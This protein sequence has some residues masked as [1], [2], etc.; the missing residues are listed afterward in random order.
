MG[1][2]LQLLHVRRGELEG[3]GGGIRKGW[4]G[5]WVGAEGEERRRFEVPVEHLSHPLF[6]ELLEAAEEEYGFRQQGA[7]TIPC[8]VD[9]FRRVQTI[10]HR[11]CSYNHHH[12]HLCFRPS[13]SS[14]SMEP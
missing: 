1:V 11:D 5:I 10:I 4:I 6:V 14:S 7:I 2:H 13:S 12:F 8:A 9:H 3:G